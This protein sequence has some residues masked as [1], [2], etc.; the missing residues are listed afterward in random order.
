MWVWVWVWTWRSGGGDLD[1]SEDAE[2]TGVGD[3]LPA[4]VVM[5]FD[6][7]GEAECEEIEEAEKA[8]L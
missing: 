8:G 2:E 5:A 6:T 1:L 3:S 4:I 7:L